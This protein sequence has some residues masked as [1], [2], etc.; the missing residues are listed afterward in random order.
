MALI[1]KP[2][3]PINSYLMRK[4]HANICMRPATNWKESKQTV[5]LKDES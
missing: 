2:S 5:G 1:R 3:C 4:N